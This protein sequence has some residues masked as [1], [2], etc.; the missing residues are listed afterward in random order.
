MTRLA[1]QGPDLPTRQI[2]HQWWRDITFVHWRVDPARLAPLMPP[3]VRPD[4]F[5]GAAGSG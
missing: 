2:M 4:L 5:D 3:G 1:E